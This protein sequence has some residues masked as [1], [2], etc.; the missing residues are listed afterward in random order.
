M[1][2]ILFLFAILTTT[3]I[4]QNVQYTP[5]FNFRTFLRG[6]TGNWIGDQTDTTNNQGLNY[7]ALKIDFILAKIFTS[8][9]AVR[10]TFKDS[11]ASSSL[12]VTLTTTQT[13]I[14]GQKRFSSTSNDFFGDTVSA[15]YL[16]GNGN[17]ITG[18]SA[19]SIAAG[20]YSNK[21][22]FNNV[23]N[24]IVGDTSIFDFTIADSI[25]ARKFLSVGTASSVD[26]EMKF[27]NASNAFT[28]QLTIA[29]PSADRSITLPNV[30]MTLMGINGGQTVTSATWNAVT[31]EVPY[32]GTGRTAFG[33]GTLLS[34]NSGGTALDT[35]P[36]VATGQILA[37]AGTN[38]KPTWSSTLSIGVITSTGLS[39]L[40][41]IKTTT[42]KPIS[43][44]GAAI[45]GN[46]TMVGGTIT[47]NT[48]AI[49]ANGIVVITRKTSGGTI[50]TAITYTI[51]AG[52]SFTINSDSVLDTSTF[53]WF[54]L[55]PY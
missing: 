53:S 46:A 13:N 20:T 24:D 49:K 52:T 15:T 12:Y 19:S 21:Y 17:G 33:R 51:V 50:G 42:I 27:F 45:A 9:F 4:A 14:T 55:T 25:R 43:T 5:T 11:I 22:W 1:K 31:I 8:S 47:V 7:N 39:L 37:S 35:I 48:T 3:M 10:Q 29:T 28:T 40:D 32:G 26:G 16:I 41:S 6:Y 54:I 38:T 18:V 34:G 44:G 36:A 30:S 2:K 23:G